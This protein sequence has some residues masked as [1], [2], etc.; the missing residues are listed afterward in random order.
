[1]ITEKDFIEAI[2]HEI[3]WLYYYAWYEDREK[4]NEK[5]DVYRDLSRMGYTKRV[6]PLDLRCPMYIL[7][8]DKPIEPGIKVE[9]LKIVQ[10]RRTDKNLTPLE[11]AI[12]I[13]PE[14]KMEFLNKLKP[15]ES[16]AVVKKTE[17]KIPK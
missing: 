11:V 7:T 6:L 9:D 3:N 16:K 15:K 14:R 8:S 13:W 12:K 4:L 5:S 2:E 1:M 10:E 17:N